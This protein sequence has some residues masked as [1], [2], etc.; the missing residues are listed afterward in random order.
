[1][2]RYL[3]ATFTLP[4]GKRKYVRAATKTELAQKLQAAKMEV[5]LGI[6]ISDAT[7]VRKY[8]ETWV[9]LTKTGRITENSETNL[10][11]AM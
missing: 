7:T 9:R 10:I 2:T 5:G 6:D 4:N 11:R 1:M 3:T 8:A